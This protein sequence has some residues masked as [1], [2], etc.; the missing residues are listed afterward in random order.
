MVKISHKGSILVVL[1][2]IFELCFAYALVEMIR[3]DS[4][5][6]AEQVRCRAINAQTAALSKLFNDSG[7]A[8]GGYSIAKS[9]LFATRFDTIVKQIP[10]DVAELSDLV[11]DDKECVASMQRVKQITTDGVKTLAEA[12]AAIE[13]NHVDVAQFRARHMYKEIRQLADQLQDE[14][15]GISERADNRAYGKRVEVA[16]GLSERSSRALVIIGGVAVNS[17]MAILLLVFIFGI[18]R[19]LKTV[20]DNL[21]KLE[22]GE[23]LGTAL[24]GSDEIAQIDA[25][26]RKMAAKISH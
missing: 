10:Q 12:K 22:R 13:D 5:R 7:V 14:L 11:S 6:V 3:Q 15:A 8:M 17:L 2:L 9:P 20:S 21:G 16:G 4:E 26:V 19:R 1:S 25:A 23:E 24:K 18:L